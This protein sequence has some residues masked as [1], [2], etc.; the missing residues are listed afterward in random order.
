MHKALAAST[1]FDYETHRKAA[2]QKKI[3]KSRPDRILIKK[4]KPKARLV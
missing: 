1:P 2:V 3:E 4:K